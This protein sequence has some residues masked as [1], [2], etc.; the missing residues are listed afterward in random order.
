MYKFAHDRIRESACDL[1]NVRHH[2]HDNVDH[3]KDRVDLKAGLNWSV[4][5]VLC[6]QSNESCVAL[7]RNRLL[8]LAV[9]RLSLGSACVK[10]EDHDVASKMSY[11]SLS[12][13]FLRCGLA[14]F[15]GTW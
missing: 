10:G 7:A 3:E 12:A 14:L 6:R 5:K 4:G 2:H 1:L 9:R 11:F 13:D 15:D 8:P